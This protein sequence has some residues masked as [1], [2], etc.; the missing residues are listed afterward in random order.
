MTQEQEVCRMIVR[1]LAAQGRADGDLE[2][3]ART[4]LSEDGLALTS[5]ELVRLLV[6]LEEHLE[7]EL[8]DVA[9]MNAHFETVADILALV[10]VSLAPIG[11]A[12]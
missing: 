4:S 8:D 11:S 3:T 2:V 10:D 7:I 1:L 6:N 12:G 5:L 9:V